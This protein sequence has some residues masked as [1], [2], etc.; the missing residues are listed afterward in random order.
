[1][2]QVQTEIPIVSMITCT[3]CKKGFDELFFMKNEKQLKNCTVC[4]AK[5]RM[6]AQKNSVAFQK[7]SGNKIEDV[8][9]N[10][11]V[12]LYIEQSITMLTALKSL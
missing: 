11:I 9:K 1:M 2:A 3:K 12:Q 10:Q 8:K 5:N 4:R 7:L 6:T